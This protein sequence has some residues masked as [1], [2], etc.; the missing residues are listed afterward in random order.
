MTYPNVNLYIVIYIYIIQ[1]LF[2]IE[3]LVAVA[4]TLGLID[5]ATD[6]CGIAIVTNQRALLSGS[7]Q[8]ERKLGRL[9]I[10]CVS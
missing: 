7:D 9:R 4:M 3:L 6:R 8:P 5:G 1:A 2:S 10:L